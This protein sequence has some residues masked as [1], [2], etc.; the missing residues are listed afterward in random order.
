MGVRPAHGDTAWFS[1]AQNATTHTLTT[2]AVAV[3][4]SGARL[5]FDLFL[6]TEETDRLALERSSDGGATWAPQ[7]FQ[8]RDRGETSSTDGVV[9]G[10]GD[11]RWVQA[12]ADLA[13]GELLLRW[14]YTTDPG[15]LGR[16]VYVDDIL[17][18]SRGGA[19][20]DG[21]KTP[22]ALVADGWTLRSR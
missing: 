13:P 17:V 14:R 3:P 6:D 12:R 15:Y 2:P 21:E 5:G 9:S 18:A 11:R 4:A 20:L 8:T 10:S 19:L 1:G 16:G 7:P 22:G